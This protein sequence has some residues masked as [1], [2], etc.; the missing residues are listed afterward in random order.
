MELHDAEFVVAPQIEGPRER[1]DNGSGFGKGP[2]EGTYVSD[3]DAQ[4]WL[5]RADAFLLER[6]SR[7]RDHWATVFNNQVP[8]DIHDLCNI[9]Q[10]DAHCV[11]QAIAVGHLKEGSTDHQGLKRHQL[12]KLTG[13]LFLKRGKAVQT[14]LMDECRRYLD[15]QE[16]VALLAIAKKHPELEQED[17]PAVDDDLADLASEPDDFPTRA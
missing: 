8:S 12:G 14:W 11:K 13:I 9:F 3:E 15:E 10:L 16:R 2:F 5:T 6:N 4:R 1:I 7:W 17:E